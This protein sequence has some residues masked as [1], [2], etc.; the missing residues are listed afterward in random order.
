MKK[1]ILSKS[2]DDAELY[3]HKYLHVSIA[4]NHIWFLIILDHSIVLN[5]PEKYSRYV[6]L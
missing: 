6:I 3:Y 2:L 4:D 5:K 1:D